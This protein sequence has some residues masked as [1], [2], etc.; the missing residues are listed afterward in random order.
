MDNPPA[1]TTKLR[2]EIDGL[3]RL[4]DEGLLKDPKSEDF[5]R[6][7]AVGMEGLV[8]IK[9]IELRYMHRYLVA[10][11]RRNTAFMVAAVFGLQADLNGRDS[12][13]LH[14]EVFLHSMVARAL[15]TIGKDDA[16]DWISDF[17][18]NIFTFARKRKALREYLDEKLGELDAQ[19]ALK[20]PKKDEA[21]EAA[22]AN[23]A[24]VDAAAALLS[25][26]DAH[27]DH[28]DDTDMQA[29]ADALREQISAGAI[30]PETAHAL[31]DAV[32]A[33]IDG[34]DDADLKAAKEALEG[35]LPRELIGSPTP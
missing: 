3:L 33:H 25:E 1:L 31:L 21:A 34:S 8:R 4:G 16:R 10:L 5:Q 17:G 18:E 14:N 2:R 26:V 7:L 15:R 30:L 28:G 6:P 23:K 24:I 29:A 32:D 11:E 13:N 12:P 20:Y 22:D 19:V 27:L 9:Q 35:F